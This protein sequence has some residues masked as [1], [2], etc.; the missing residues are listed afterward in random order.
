LKKLA[1]ILILGILLVQTGGYRLIM[2]YRQQQANA[3]LIAQLD[4]AAYN[5]NELIEISAP[6][7]LPYYTDWQDFE[8]CDGQITVKGVLYNYV[9]RKYTNNVMVYKCIA[10]KEAQKIKDATRQADKDA[11]SATAGTRHKKSSSNHSVILKLLPE[12]ENDC[13]RFS[14]S[15]A[16]ANIAAGYPSFTPGLLLN[17]TDVATPPPNRA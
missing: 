10:N 6:L 3:A 9:A 16:T 15:A 1:V 2:A 7:D 14:C 8:R 12:Y 5:E 17:A 11:L 4:Q 13:Y